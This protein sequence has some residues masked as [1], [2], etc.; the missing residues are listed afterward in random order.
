MMVRI[1][2]ILLAGAAVGVGVLWWQ[3]QRSGLLTATATTRVVRCRAA[4]DI[5]TC[6]PVGGDP[7]TTFPPNRLA[8]TTL[9]FDHPVDGGD[10]AII[11]H[12]A[13]GSSGSFRAAPL[14][15]VTTLP[16][17]V[18]STCDLGLVGRMAD[19]T[20]DIIYRGATIGHATVTVQPLA[21]RAPQGH[22]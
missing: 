15:H 8:E 16:V 20:L 4:T 12:M 11:G 6:T 10:V 1:V 5:T 3:G 19:N 9:T 21:H 7:A 18:L 22:C 14:S 13:D 2:G 17:F